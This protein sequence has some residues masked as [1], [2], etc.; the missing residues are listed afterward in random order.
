MRSSSNVGAAET[1]RWSASKAPDWTGWN[2]QQISDRLR[3][4]MVADPGLEFWC[5]DYSAAESWIVA[6]DAQDEG[7]IAA[8]QTGDPHTTVAKMIYPD[9][10][11]WTGDLAADKELASK[12]TFDWDP[13]HPLRDHMKRVQHGG[14]MGRT[15]AGI[16]RQ[17]HIPVS[18]AE[19]FFELMY[20]PEGAFP[21]IKARHREIAEQLK[22]TGTTV[23]CLGR[24]RQF[25]GRTWDDETLREALGQLEQSPVADVLNLAL[26]RVWLDLDLRPNI[27]DAPA[28]H[29][30]NR[31]WL[32][33]QVHDAIWGL[34]RIG[35]DDALRRVAELMT[36]PIEING[37]L[38]TIPVEIKVG[39]SPAKKELRTWQG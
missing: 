1:G 14:N 11:P 13:H 17:L 19:K 27:H 32:I 3:G 5:A 22:R 25:F 6:Y 37:R 2:I 39:K 34:R 24:K 36:I 23:S 16:A 20:G 30:P 29:Q 8:H 35:D 9:L 38:C 33:A 26:L 4:I 15:P 21:R 18:E 28:P 12:Y 10:L 7:Y 31:V